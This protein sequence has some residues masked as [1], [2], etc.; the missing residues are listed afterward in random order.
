MLRRL[1]YNSLFLLGIV[2]AVLLLVRYTLTRPITCAPDC[3]GLNLLDR[4]LRGVD[5]RKA[6]LINAQLQDADLRG[7]NLREA[8]L[9]GANL[10]HVNLRNADLSDAKLIGADLTQADL[11]ESLMNG[12]DLSGANLAQ[13]D[14]TGVNL[15][16]ALLSGASFAQAKLTDAQLQ[17]ANLAGIEFTQASLAGANLEAANLSGANLSRAD[18]SGANLAQVDLTGSWLNLANLTGANLSGADLAG[19]S[20]IGGQL[21]SANLQGSKLAGAVLIGANLDGANLRGADLTQ[22][23]VLKAQ[24]DRHALRLDPA[25][26][27]LNELQIG[28]LIQDAN[29]NGVQFDSQTVWPANLQPR[30]AVASKAGGLPTARQPGPEGTPEGTRTQG[31]PGTPQ[32]LRSSTQVT[33][34]TAVSMVT[35][36]NAMSSTLQLAHTPAA[37]QVKVSFLFNSI[38][39]INS[40]TGTFDA[41]LYIDLFWYDPALVGKDLTALDPATLWDPLVW[42][43]NVRNSRLLFKSY[44]NSSEPGTNVQLIYGLAGTFFTPFDLHNFPFDRQLISLKLEAATDDSD[45]LLLDF[46]NLERPLVQTEK[47]FIQRIPKSRYVE[48]DAVVDAWT[49]E[50]A[51]VVEQLHLYAYDKS[52]WSQLRI[53][54]ILTRQANPYLWKFI[55]VLFSLML[56]AWSVLLLEGQAL[57]YRLWL[58]F[59]LFVSTTV[60]NTLMWKFL[61]RIAYRTLLD[62]YL[63]LCYSAILLIAAVAVLV[64]VLYDH[65]LNNWAKW[66]NRGLVIVYPA[67]L[68]GINLDLYWRSIP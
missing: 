5:L 20:L 37:K 19:S 2:A 10:T 38:R 18:L 60:F 24:L 27:A 23:R 52:S 57:H 32:A 61:P 58:L 7:A 3:I 66:L 54:L 34:T 63:I 26:K 50:E 36:A 1:G 44:V 14:L 33:T 16:E 48:P 43:L 68:T 67:L 42:P 28:Q 65:N 30:A 64:K 45:H 6:N 9:S 4:D 25:L 59:I 22:I 53:D 17:G 47:P 13:A 56:V 51:R 39:N 41:D 49:L 12:A 55:F 46:I 8:D 40:Q 21:A 15:T 62:M 11:G 29:L 31:V 35:P